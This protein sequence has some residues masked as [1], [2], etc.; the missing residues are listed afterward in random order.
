MEVHGQFFKPR[1]DASALFHPA[2]AL[3][4]DIAASIGP[5][6]KPDHR[7]SLASSLSYVGSARLDLL[8]AEPISQTLHAI[9]FV[10]RQLPGFMPTT[11]RLTPPSNQEGDRLADDRLGTRR[12]V[13]LAGRDFDGKR[14]SRTVSDHVEFRSRPAFAAAQCVIGRFVGMSPETFLSAPAAAGGPN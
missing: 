14:S 9:S 3:L 7:I 5:A 13:D 4:G 12:F 11:Q 10:T 1:A 6:V 8:R 2:D